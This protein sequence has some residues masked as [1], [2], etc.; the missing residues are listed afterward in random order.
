[1]N[2]TRLLAVVST[3]RTAAGINFY[4]V[5]PA[6]SG[7]PAQARAAPVDD[8]WRPLETVTRLG[9]KPAFRLEPFFPFSP[10]TYAGTDGNEEGGR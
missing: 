8:H 2:I 4:F 10:L 3:M 7:K 9:G 5:K 1:M 6:G